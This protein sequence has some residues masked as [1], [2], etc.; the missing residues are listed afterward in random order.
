MRIFFIFI[1]ILSIVPKWQ[2]NAQ[3]VNVNGRL[4]S[5]QQEA[6]A[7]S[8]VLLLKNDSINYATISNESG[9]FALPNVNYGEYTLHIS[10]LGYNTRIDTINVNANT[11]IG[12]IVLSNTIDILD[13]VVVTDNSNEYANRASFIISQYAKENAVNSYDALK[14]VPMLIVDPLQKTINMAGGVNTLILI[15]GVKRDRLTLSAIDPKKIQRVEVVVNPSSRYLIDGVTGVV[16]IIVKAPNEPGYYGNISTQQNYAFKYGNTWIGLRYAKEKWALYA[17]GQNFYFREHD[18]REKNERY[19]YQN[20]DTILIKQDG[21]GKYNKMMNYGQIGFDIFPTNNSFFTASATFIDDRSENKLLQTGE[22]TKNNSKENT[23]SIY[24]KS[25]SPYYSHTYNAYYETKLNDKGTKIAFDGSYNRHKY[26]NE[27]IYE[28]N[29]GNSKYESN[30]TLTNKK[31]S[32]DFETV[33]TLPTKLIDIEAGFRTYWQHTKFMELSQKVEWEEW[34]N[35]LHVNGNGKLGKSFFYQMGIGVANVSSDVSGYKHN[36]WEFLPSISVK[37]KISNSN[38][39]SVE[40]NKGRN[41][42]SILYLNPY[43][44]ASDTLTISRGNPYLTPYY[45]NKFTLRYTYS[46]GNLYFS[47]YLQYTYCDDYIGQL[48]FLNSDNIYI[49]TYDNINSYSHISLGLN[50]RLQLKKWG[51]INGGI[52]SQK[53]Y[54]KNRY[55][56]GWGIGYNFNASANYK[57]FRLSVFWYQ[58]PISY[59][60][61]TK[62]VI[63]SES[64]ITL[65][66]SGIKNLS[67]SI[68]ARWLAGYTSKT[69][70]KGANYY[71]YYYQKQEDRNWM[72]LLGIEYSFKSEKQ[73]KQRQKSINNYDTGVNM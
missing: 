24:S 51:M 73:A 50:L 70:S 15:N 59:S 11:N 27:L 64:N 6:I 18:Y 33:F 34:R 57:N 30:R 37:Y 47:P 63:A 71:N 10:C 36:Y 12:V 40:Y 32:V 42:L 53:N 56:D 28:E 23:Y 4:L 62:S 22:I 5:T 9:N 29:D 44:T 52:Y 3:T 16:N 41:S 38:S 55:Y 8:T 20:A 66:W 72:I 17:S 68:G 26:D 21:N 58:T 67:L 35:Y 43:N 61:N 19:T 1:I 25:K 2:L 49:T 7:Y 39:V 13:E 14:E 60:T 54:L 48:S 31:Q 65:A 45:N 46:K 69:Y